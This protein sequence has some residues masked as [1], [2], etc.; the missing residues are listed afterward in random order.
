MAQ[1]NIGDVV[2]AYPVVFVRVGDVM[3]DCL[4]D[5]SPY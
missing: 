2:K 5:V 3:L 4:D 1:V